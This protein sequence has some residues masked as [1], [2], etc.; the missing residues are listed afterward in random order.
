M[1]KCLNFTSRSKHVS[2]LFTLETHLEQSRRIDI[3]CFANTIGKICETRI[4]DKRQRLVPVRHLYGSV[5]VDGKGLSLKWETIFQL[6]DFSFNSPP[7]GIE[8]RLCASCQLIQVRISMRQKGLQDLILYHII[9]ASTCTPLLVEVSK[10]SQKNSVSSGRTQD[11][12]ADIVGVAETRG[13]DLVQGF[14]SCKETF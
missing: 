6:S 10:R 12:E 7:P 4:S 13:H 5:S 2:Y 8:N 9:F 1:R 11:V 14:Y 3:E